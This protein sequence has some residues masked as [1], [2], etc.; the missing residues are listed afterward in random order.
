MS[1]QRTERWIAEDSWEI[2]GLFH[3]DRGVARLVLDQR[4]LPE[5]VP[6]LQ[7]GDDPDILHVDRAQPF[8]DDVHRVA[9]VTLVDDDLPAAEDVLLHAVRHVDELMAVRRGC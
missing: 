1:P 5:V 8:L 7:L 2:T 6:S 4:D 3:R 9:D